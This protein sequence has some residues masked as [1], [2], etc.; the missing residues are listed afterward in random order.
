MV[1]TFTSNVCTL[2]LQLDR[3]VRYVDYLLRKH[4]HTPLPLH[5]YDFYNNTPSQVSHVTLFSPPSNKNTP[6]RNINKET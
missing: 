3:A 5:L 4:H 2:P 6:A 1:Y